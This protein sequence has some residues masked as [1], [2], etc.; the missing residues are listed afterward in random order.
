MESHNRASGG[1]RVEWS[2]EYAPPPPPPQR[3]WG[4]DELNERQR[5]GLGR[6]SRAKPPAVCG[7]NRREML[8][9]GNRWGRLRAR[10][11]HESF[12]WQLSTMGT[13]LSALSWL[14]SYPAIHQGATRTVCII[15]ELLYDGKEVCVLG[16]LLTS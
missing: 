5:S 12:S 16:Q 7:G 1:S 15:S 2:N 4:D 3:E 9:G 11:F 8:D 14:P 6:C 10:M 13:C